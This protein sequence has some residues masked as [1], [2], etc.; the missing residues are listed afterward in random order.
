[1]T[2]WLAYMPPSP[3]SLLKSAV[4]QAVERTAAVEDPES[5]VTDAMSWDTC[6]ETAPETKALDLALHLEMESPTPGPL[7]ERLNLGAEL[8][9]VGPRATRNMSRRATFVVTEDAI[10]DVTTGVPQ[11]RRQHLRR[12]QHQPRRQ[13]QPPLL[14]G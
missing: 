14:E 4:E 2:S 1:M 8:V 7:M 9:V 10:E 6:P 3:S 5:A 11:H 13:L 12:P